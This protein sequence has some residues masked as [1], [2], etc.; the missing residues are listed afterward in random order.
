MA[1]EDQ[2]VSGVRQDRTV[3]WAPTEGSLR[4]AV[5]PVAHGSRRN[6][7]PAR[8]V[9]GPDLYALRHQ[10]AHLQLED[11]ESMELE[12]Q[13]LLD[14]KVPK[15]VADREHLVLMAEQED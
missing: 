11:Q 2:V 13:E 10:Q 6:I 15:Q 3:E 4:E 14:L 7:P 8:L 1:P 9:P 5:V 12:V